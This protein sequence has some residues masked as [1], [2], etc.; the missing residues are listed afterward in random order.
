MSCYHFAKTL[1]KAKKEKLREKIHFNNIVEIFKIVALVPNSL[2]S[3]FFYLQLPLCVRTE[4]RY[5]KDMIVGR[6][7]NSGD[8]NHP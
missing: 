8:Y 1:L 5:S 7:A 3:G 4:I 2:E 6:V